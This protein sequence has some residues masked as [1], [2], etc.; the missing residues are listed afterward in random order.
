M[1]MLTLDRP[2]RTMLAKMLEKHM[3]EDGKVQTSVPGLWL[4]RSAH[5]NQRG[6]VVYE[7]SLYVVA[8]GSK[9]AYFGR[10]TYSYDALNFLLLTV[11]LPLEAQVVRASPDEP[12]LAVR[13]ELDMNMVTELL[14][15]LDQGV[16]PVSDIVLRGI[17]SSRLD[18]EMSDAVLRLVKTLES[19][20]RSRILGPI[21]TR[22]ILF[23]LLQGELGHILRSFAR[24]DRHNHQVARVLQFIQ[25][26][27]AQALEVNDLALLANMSSSS[28]HNHFK[29][30]TGYSPLQYI[31]SLRLHE[32]RRMIQQETQSVSDAAYR[33]GYVSA[34]QFSRE[35]KRMFGETPSRDGV[36]WSIL[37]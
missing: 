32:A 3:P 31:K 7:P 19:G 24:Q 18:S 1:D 34:S 29:T 15:E 8:Q 11:P 16:K 26:N 17:C 4:I 33:V 36:G 30:V 23:H 6:P 37:R 5:T 13:L 28:F 21:V 27:Y 12:Y 20:P 25:K 10:E 22:E 14:M 2:P 35:Y 9:C